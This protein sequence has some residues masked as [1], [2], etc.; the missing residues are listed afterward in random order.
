VK[1]LCYGMWLLYPLRKAWLHICNSEGGLL[2]SVQALSDICRLD[3][4]AGADQL[5]GM[6]FSHPRQHFDHR[7][8]LTQVEHLTPHFRQIGIR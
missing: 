4:G 7:P 8:F 3:D 5:R 1:R 6:P 2:A